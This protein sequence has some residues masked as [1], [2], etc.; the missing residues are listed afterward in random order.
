MKNSYYTQYEYDKMMEKDLA[1][2]N[3]MIST[4]CYLTGIGLFWM[5]SL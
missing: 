3:I 1:F 5:A 4:I 2:R